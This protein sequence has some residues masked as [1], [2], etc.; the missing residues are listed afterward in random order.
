MCGVTGA[1]E[2][3]AMKSPFHKTFCVLAI[4]DPLA[5]FQQEFPR[6]IRSCL[7]EAKVRDFQRGRNHQQPV[8]WSWILQNLTCFAL[9]PSFLEGATFAVLLMVQSL[10]V[11][12]RFLPA[13]TDE[14]TREGAKK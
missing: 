14:T 7:C 11:T 3:I 13:C 1:Y 8:F 5:C 12:T 6:E 4:S 2:E 9:L 10:V